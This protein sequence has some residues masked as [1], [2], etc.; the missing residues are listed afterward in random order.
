MRLNRQLL[1]RFTLGGSIAAMAI[2]L[3]WFAV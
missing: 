1:R 3:S 2:T